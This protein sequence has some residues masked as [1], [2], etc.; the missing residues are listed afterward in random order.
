MV[1]LGSMGPSA[2]VISCSTLHQ[3][4]SN[5]SSLC[6][7]CLLRAHLKSRW[8]FTSW[9]R[10]RCVGTCSS[11]PDHLFSHCLRNDWQVPSSNATPLTFCRWVGEHSRSR[12]SRGTLRGVTSLDALEQTDVRRTWCSYVS[13]WSQCESQQLGSACSLQIKTG[14][15]RC[16][17]VE[18]VNQGLISECDNHL[19]AMKSQTSLFLNNSIK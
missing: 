5:M 9:S 19:D 16:V 7:T 14:W 2:L 8:R 18:V 12:T 11:W 10:T 6:F 13:F 3:L 17:F 15:R 4:S 1:W